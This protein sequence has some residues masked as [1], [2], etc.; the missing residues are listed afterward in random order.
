LCGCVGV[1]D[2]RDVGR[3]TWDGMSP[4]VGGG[5]G[6]ASMDS[7][8]FEERRADDG[9]RGRV[10]FVAMA[11]L[12]L[13]LL[14]VIYTAGYFVFGLGFTPG[15]N[16]KLGMR[17]FGSGWLARAYRPAAGVESW[18]RGYEVRTG[19]EEDLYSMMSP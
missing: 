12:V 16:R 9:S 1:E 3:G 2:W 4:G 17:V 6:R 15:P 10:L 5:A 7:R 13:A 14:T 8:H 11:A 18:V 19:T